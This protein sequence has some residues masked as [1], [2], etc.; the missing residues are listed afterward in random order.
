MSCAARV[1]RPAA[2]VAPAT[3]A[4][5]SAPARER[6]AKLTCAWRA[7]ARA[8]LAVTTPTAGRAPAVTRAAASSAASGT[9]ASA[10][11][12]GGGGDRPKIGPHQSIAV[13]GPHEHRTGMRDTAL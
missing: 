3:G 6:P 2:V 13:I 8:R 4:T 10:G 9:A 12:D 5:G 7:A 1:A 11:A